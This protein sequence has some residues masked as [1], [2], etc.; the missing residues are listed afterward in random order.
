MNKRPHP[1]YILWVF[2]RFS[3]IFVLSLMRRLFVTGESNVN[4][5][6]SSLWFDLSLLC[7]LITISIAKW[8]LYNIEYSATL[9]T[10]SKGIIKRR[11][12][13]IPASRV[14]V[15]SAVRPWYMRPLGALL[16]Q[17]DTCGG[18]YSS[19]DFVVPVYAAQVSGLMG[20]YSLT[21]SYRARPWQLAALSMVAS[22]SFAGILL[23]ATA[24][25]QTGRLLGPKVANR[26]FG[27]LEE[28]ARLA[29]FGI[30][31]ATALV[32]YM[33]LLGWSV[34]FLLNLQRHSRFSLTR[35][36]HHILMQAGALVNRRT[37]FHIPDIAYLDIRRSIPTVLL[38]LYSV[39]VAT[40]G[41]RGEKG[42]ISTLIP[43]E[44]RAGMDKH[45]ARLLPELLPSPVSLR[46]T[47]GAIVR[48]LSLP[49]LLLCVILAS[50]PILI[51][52]SPQLEDFIRFATLIVII[53]IL[54]YGII[55]VLDYF[56]TGVS[57]RGGVYTLR[58]SRGFYLHTAV[59]PL[60]K[61]ALVTLRQSPLQQRFGQCDLS[62]YSYLEN[63]LVRHT[64]LSLDR[65]KAEV[66]IIQNPD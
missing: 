21:G 49:L 43:S 27:S 29:R 5:G 1:I 55:R 18:S 6:Q 59:I 62:V 54:W 10:I 37:L 11:T 24:I 64:V 30:P 28:L 41:C 19:A 38:G 65:M 44:R 61:A 34:A 4:S 2:F 45:L 7:M 52:L 25:G 53:P 14:A 20:E 63:R 17:I 33:V 47:K 50:S 58:Y 66:L 8:L 26:F 56:Y 32:G 48:F 42:D 40:A 39:F 16:L 13:F 31:P 22:N 12:I 60:N 57:F 23:I 35:V 46:C 51:R 3:L 36:N 15:L 9:F